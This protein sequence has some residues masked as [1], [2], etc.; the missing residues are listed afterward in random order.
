[1]FTG[2]IEEIGHVQRIARG[3]KAIALT[4]RAEKVLEE[5]ALGDSIA[6]NGTCLTVTRRTDAAFT[7]DVAPE[8]M[9]RTAFAQLQEGDPVNLERAL[10]LRT[11]LGGHFVSGHVDGVGTI[12]KEE[13]EENAVL[14]TVRIPSAL[15][16]YTIEKGSVAVD[17]VSLTV[18]AYGKDWFTVSLIPHTAALTTLLGKAIGASVNIETDL[19]GKYVERMLQGAEQQPTGKG[20]LTLDFLREHGF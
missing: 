14:L 1:M 12:T 13:R 20:A 11:R 7:A 17:G 9:R 6:V 15:G 19:I 10:T 16:R 5:L 2:I 4:V 8:T 3:G 18:A